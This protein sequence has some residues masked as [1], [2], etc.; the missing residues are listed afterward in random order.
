MWNSRYQYT[1]A[2]NTKEEK[3]F[4]SPIINIY[5]VTNRKLHMSCP[6]Q[7]V[8]AN[9]STSNGKGTQSTDLL[10]GQ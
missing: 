10:T 4:Y 1:V 9:T 8:C 5:Q 6:V 7:A 2:G 3:A